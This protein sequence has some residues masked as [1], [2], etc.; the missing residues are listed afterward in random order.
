[1]QKRS[2]KKGIKHF[3][4]YVSSLST[5]SLPLSAAPPILLLLSIFFFSFYFIMALHS[6]RR[7]PISP[8][9]VGPVPYATSIIYIYV[10]I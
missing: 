5:S 6:R 3:Y 7:L 4:D 8:A 1:M 9:L 10:F 2:K